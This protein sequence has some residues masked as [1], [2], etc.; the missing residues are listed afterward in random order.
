M[1]TNYSKIKILI[2]DDHLLF[3][4]GLKLLLSTLDFITTIKEASNYEE[5]KSH[6]NMESFDLLLLDIQFG[7]VDG[8]EIIFEI[9]KASPNLKIIA[10]TS[11]SDSITISTALHSGFDGYL[12]KTDS[13]DEIEKALTQV[14]EGNKYF[15]SQVK[16]IVISDFSSSQK[17]NLTNREKEVLQLIVK[18]K[19][20]KEIAEILFLSEKTI[21]TYRSNL[22]LKLEVKNIAGLVRKAIMN[23][24]VEL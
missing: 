4:D 21:E 3:L 14:Y 7:T 6:L 23:G 9:K 5:L 16:D 20:T 8:R 12:V 11:F 17:T 22:F 18:E 13:R 19:T 24:L 1:L 2:A 10:L 15:S